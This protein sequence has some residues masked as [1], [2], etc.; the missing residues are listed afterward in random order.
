MTKTISII[1]FKATLLQSKAASLTFLHL[2]KNVSTKLPSR[3]MTA[4]E[5][6]INGSPFQAALEPDGKGSHWLRVD[7][8]MREAA[9]ANV[10]DTVTLDITP[11]QE[12]LEPKL[13]VDVR[14]A[15]AAAP[16]A[17][18]VWADIT[19]SARRDWIHWITSAK[20]VET[21]SRRI[22]NACS[23]LTTGK[24]RVCCF[25]RS[26]MYSNSMRCPVAD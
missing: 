21:R 13:P 10:G 1:H 22:K 9:H 24:R 12:E 15:L 18:K 7:K 14:K 6:T 3:G 19:P 11:M 8:K 5:G 17:R 2:P 16:K 26:G 23:M 20:Q 4:V 25:D